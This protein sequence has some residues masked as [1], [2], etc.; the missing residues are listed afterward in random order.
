MIEVVKYSM[1]PDSYIIVFIERRKCGIG[2]VG[3]G[4][5]VEYYFL[6]G[7]FSCNGLLKDRKSYEIFLHENGFLKTKT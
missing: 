2:N 6:G 4:I 5:L 1:I 7:G 3:W